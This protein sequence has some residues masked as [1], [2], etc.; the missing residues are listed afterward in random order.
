[1]LK[2][3]SFLWQTTKVMRILR[4]GRKQEYSGTFL[5][6]FVI[7]TE[8][9][10]VQVH[11]PVCPSHPPLLEV[12]FHCCAPESCRVAP[13][14]C[15]DQRLLRCPWALNTACCLSMHACELKVEQCLSSLYSKILY[16]FLCWQA[17]GKG[18]VLQHVKCGNTLRTLLPSLEVKAGRLHEQV[19]K[20][21]NVEVFAY[22][23]WS[24]F[25]IFQSVPHR[26]LL[27]FHRRFEMPQ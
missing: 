8:V 19:N 5:K 11:C 10:P 2:W 22:K 15:R 25:A 9:K 26:Y 18:W 24:L 23:C 16:S 20:Q 1:M 17:Y 21:L 7:L 12:S 14:F 27:S 13:W 3:N 6:V 4:S